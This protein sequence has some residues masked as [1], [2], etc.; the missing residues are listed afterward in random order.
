MSK[1]MTSTQF[2]NKLKEIAS[3]PTTYYSV[4]GGAWAKWN[5]KSWNFDCVILIKAILWGWSGD[6]TA[7]HGGAKWNTNGV[8]DDDANKILTRCSD[9]STDF[10]NITVGELLWMDGHVG[11]YIGNG[12][13]IECT[14]AWEGKVLYST[15]DNKGR[16]IR[17]GK[18]VYSWKKHGKL[19]YIDY[20][21]S[22]NTTKNEKVNVFYRVKTQKH[23]W[24]GE[25]KNYNDN[26]AING[27]AGWENSPITGLA[28]KVDKGSVK[29]RVHVKGGKWLGWITKYDVNDYH[30]GYAGND[31][32]IDAIQIY[33]YTP[34]SI[35]PY[36]KA[37]YK[38][39]SYDW[40]YDTET[41]GNQDGY[42]GLMGVAATKIKISIE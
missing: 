38:V 1:V 28:V 32:P 21:A 24:L 17:N 9:V 20:P 40:Q 5:G 22:T 3:L 6:K 26:D 19:S 13:V 29:Y 23:G 30:Y 7:S 10:S 35:R 41:T 16:R 11:I 39:N 8:F 12:Q 18:Q 36:K 37:K 25:V 15:I 4:S 31:K 34:D 2:I 14:A 27:Y 33:Y 42:A